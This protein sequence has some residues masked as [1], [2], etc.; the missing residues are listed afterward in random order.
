MPLALFPISTTARAHEVEIE[1][2][3]GATLH[4]E[5]N[6]VP[7][8]GESVLAWFALT[9]PGGETIP[10]ANCDCTLAVYAQTKDRPY[11]DQTPALTPDLLA[12][13]A[14]G[15][16]DIPGA[17]LTFPSVGTYTLVIS[18]KPKQEE[19]FAPFTL[20]FEKTIASASSNASPS[21]ASQSD[22]SNSKA[23]N[24]DARKPEA[25]TQTH[26]VAGLVIGLCVLGVIGVTAR[27]LRQSR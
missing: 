23:P 7:K 10:L 22:A 12:V 19:D 9:R 26:W 24:P 6:D 18:G 2:D 4:I 1:G 21:D 25:S 27:I 20:A 11:E 13:D 8:A 16:Q 5:P 14:E 15:Y 17:R 3:V